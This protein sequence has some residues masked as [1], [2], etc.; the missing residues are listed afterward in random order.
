MCSPRTSI[1]LIF[2]RTETK[3]FFETVWNAADTVF[4]LR[5][6]LIFCHVDGTPAAHSAGAPSCLVAYGAHNVAVLQRIGIRGKLII[7]RP[8][9][10]TNTI[11]TVAAT[12]QPTAKGQCRRSS[13]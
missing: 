2:A 7:L 11:T 1:A 13:A 3:A 9:L 12:T 4:F 10:L 8:L 6:R 5:G